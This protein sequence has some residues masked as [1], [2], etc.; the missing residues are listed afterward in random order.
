MTVPGLT[1]PLSYRCDVYSQFIILTKVDAN[2]FTP[3]YLTATITVYFKFIIDSTVPSTP[4]SEK[5]VLYGCVESCYDTTNPSD[6]KAYMHVTKC[7][8]GWT[9]SGYKQ[10]DYASTGLFKIPSYLR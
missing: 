10:P 2:T 6:L 4:V 7:E 9:I 3:T 8:I 1:A 5:I